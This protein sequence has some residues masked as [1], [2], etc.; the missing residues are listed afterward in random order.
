MNKGCDAK[1]KQKKKEKKE[2]YSYSL[3]HEVSTNTAVAAG[4]RS[5]LIDVFLTLK[6]RKSHLTIT[7]GKEKSLILIFCLRRKI[8][9][10]IRFL[11]AHAQSK[12]NH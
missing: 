9:R 6:A 3:V 1:S 2:L 5:A 7:A 11:L 10:S 8:E 4:A 12:K